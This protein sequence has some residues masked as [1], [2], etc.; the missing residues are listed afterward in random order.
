MATTAYST[1]KNN[2]VTFKFCF[3]ISSV[4]EIYLPKDLTVTKELE[5]LPSC[6]TLILTTQE[7]EG[8]DCGS[9]S[10]TRKKRA[11]EVARLAQGRTCV[12][13]LPPPGQAS[14]LL[15]YFA[16]A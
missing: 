14:A 12:L 7:S 10:K 9:T 4:S 5:I 13:G 11:R 15:A 8:S 2:I 6:L 16:S 3:I 1:R